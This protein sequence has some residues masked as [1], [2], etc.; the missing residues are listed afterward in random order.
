LPK[1]LA[2]SWQDP[3]NIRCPAVVRPGPP[4]VRGRRARRGSCASIRNRSPEFFRTLSGHD[5]ASLAVPLSARNGHF[6]QFDC[7]S[8]TPITADRLVPP[9]HE[10]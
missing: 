5:R 9:T 10:C 1:A 6:D 8:A 2:E 3:C 7:R 4:L